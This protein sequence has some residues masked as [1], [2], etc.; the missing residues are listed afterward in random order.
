MVSKRNQILMGLGIMVGMVTGPQSQTVKA[1]QK[2][3]PYTIKFH[4]DREV[5]DANA[6]DFRV[7]AEQHSHFVD[8]V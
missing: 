4:L 2:F 3:I 6:P 5:Q 8:L 1:A 7:K